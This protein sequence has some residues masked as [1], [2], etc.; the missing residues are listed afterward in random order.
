MKYRGLGLS[1]T[2]KVFDVFKPFLLK[3]KFKRII[4]FG[5]GGGGLTLFLEDV[6]D[7]DIYTFD[8]VKRIKNINLFE[9][10][11]FTYNDIFNKNLFNNIVN[12]IKMNGRV[13]LLCDNGNKIK[14]VNTF[15]KYLK[16]DD[17]I[18]AHDYFYNK[19]DKNLWGSCE[20]MEKDVNTESLKPFYNK[21]FESIFWMSKIKI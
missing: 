14:E 9:N 21:E 13:L 2:E 16:K 3:E 20:I 17:V 1:Q 7:C 4:E 11:V 8:T 15:S 5:T 19:H 10:V 18:M 12:L 6:T